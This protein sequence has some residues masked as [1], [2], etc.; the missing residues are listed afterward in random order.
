MCYVV[1][2]LC[3]SLSPPSLL[4]LSH[5]SPLFLLLPPPP[6]PPLSFSPTDLDRQRVAV[7]WSQ[8]SASARSPG[9]P[10]RTISNLLPVLRL[11]PPDTD[12]V[13]NHVRVQAL[14]PPLHCRSPKHSMVSHA[15]VIHST[16]VRTYRQSFARIV[17]VVVKVL[18]KK[19]LNCSMPSAR[20]SAIFFPLRE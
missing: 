13:P 5:P 18:A 17:G 4:S 9:P 3:S 20:N 11:C 16:Y 2:C 15:H 1:D 14:L 6:I 10:Q 19:Q 8:V 12:P 7:I